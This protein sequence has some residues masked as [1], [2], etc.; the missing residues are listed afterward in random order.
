MKKIKRKYLYLG[1][2]ILVVIA[3]F[4][5]LRSRNSSGTSE[6]RYITEAAAK[7]TLTNSISASG[8]ISVDQ[9]ATVD[10]TITGT[11]SGLSVNVGDSVSEGDQLFTI[12]N[13][14]LDVAV[15]KAVS[16]YQQAL[17]AVESAEVA[18]DQA[19]ANYEK[20]ED[21]DDED[22][23]S[24]TKKELQVLE[25]KIDLAEAD[26]VQA[27]TSL[28]ASAQSL[29]SAKDD[30]AERTVT[31][32]LSG[33]ILEI[34]IENGDDLSKNSDNSSESPI[35]IG[36]LSTLKVT[37]SINEVDIANVS[38]GQKATLT[39]DA[40]T[41]LSLTGTV[42]TIDSLGASDSGVVTYDVTIGFDTLDDRLKPE[43]T[44]SAEIIT[45]A[46]QDALIVPSSAVNGS[47]GNFSVMV[48]ENG[49][50]VQKTVRIGTSN[51]TQTEILSGLSEGDEVVTQ[52][53][54]V[55]SS[56]SSSSDSDDRE[57]SSSGGG[58]ILNGL[59]GGGSRPGGGSGP[60]SRD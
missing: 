34:N 46:K 14:D 50:P 44:A 7:G 18:K 26:I 37:V 31:A 25:D 49:Q 20:A 6:V 10:P 41:D 1:A 13:D 23:D 9:I 58:G 22:S 15:T 16:S 12:I 43:M 54:T 17:N 11:V 39:F 28:T 3:G 59:T 42:E 38:V 21:E 5:Y 24:Y 48:L 33:T 53:V 56:T 4:F 19:K 36:D 32:P 57:A 30:A 29:K 51:N 47:N 2:I 52:T 27:K 35:I 60:P 40:I 45:E 8:N 55:D